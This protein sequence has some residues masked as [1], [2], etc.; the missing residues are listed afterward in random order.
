MK[1]A[2]KLLQKHKKEKRKQWYRGFLGV[3]ADLL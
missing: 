3:K 2:K 1:E